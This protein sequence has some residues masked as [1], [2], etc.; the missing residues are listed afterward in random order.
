MNVKQVVDAVIEQMIAAGLAADGRIFAGHIYPQNIQNGLWSV[1]PQPGDEEGGNNANYKIN[2]SIRI[3]G[4]DTDVSLLYQA[5]AVIRKS[6][7]QF[8]I[9]SPEVI[10]VT[11]SSPS[12]D[13]V[14]GFEQRQVSWT[15]NVKTFVPG[16]ND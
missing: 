6:L 5:D 14:L 2:Y 12:D 13:D 11:L 10:S 7:Q 9:D 16:W 3:S 8:R 1:T 4:Y 15:V